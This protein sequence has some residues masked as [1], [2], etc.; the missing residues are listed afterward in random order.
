M[1]DTRFTLSDLDAIVRTHWQQTSEDLV[2]TY[3][4]LSWT[5]RRRAPP[6]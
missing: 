6:P 4:V 3:R 2:L 1:T 5:P